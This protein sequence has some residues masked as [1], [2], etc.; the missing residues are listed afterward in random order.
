LLEIELVPNDLFN[1]IKNKC[2]NSFAVIFD[3]SNDETYILGR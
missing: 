1:K 3:I 2:I